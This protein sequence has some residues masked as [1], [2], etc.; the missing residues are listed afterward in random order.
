MTKA[1][2]CLKCN[3]SVPGRGVIEMERWALC[4]DILMSQAKGA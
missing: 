4:E 3:E 1:P 2:P